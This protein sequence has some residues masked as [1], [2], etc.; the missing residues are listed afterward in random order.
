[1]LF[2]S[3]FEFNPDGSTLVSYHYPA[4][5]VSYLTNR[6]FWRDNEEN[7]IYGRIDLVLNK[8]K[9]KEIV[10][11]LDE[12]YENK[13]RA[14]FMELMIHEEYFYSDYDNY[15]PEFE[16]IVLTA[17]KWCAEHSYEGR[18]FGS[19]MFEKRNTID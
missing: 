7:I 8:F 14:G 9:L 12:I 4:E 15:I 13:T 2:R 17:A 3:Y 19:V 16:E 6:D 1:M 10:P 11:L 18:T 5:L